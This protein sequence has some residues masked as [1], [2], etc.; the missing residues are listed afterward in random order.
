MD[1]CNKILIAR[2]DK[3]LT[4]V[5]LAKKIGVNKT[6]VLRWENGHNAPDAYMLTKIAAATDKPVS[7]FVTEQMDTHD[8]LC[9]R[10]Q[11]PAY[12]KSPLQLSP[13]IIDALQDP[14]AVRALLVAHGN[15]DIDKN[16]REAILILLR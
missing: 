8:Q 7:F 16:K 12:N 2:R 15:T 1:L 6:T 13:E 3:G 4:Q 10:E 14:I 5:G 9:V 11:G